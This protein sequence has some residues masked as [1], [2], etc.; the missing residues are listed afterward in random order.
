MTF[1]NKNLK[2]TFEYA[3]VGDIKDFNKNTFS[4]PQFTKI[5]YNMLNKNKWRLLSL[6][7]QNS[8]NNIESAKYK[9]E[10][11]TDINTGIATLKD[12]LYFVDSKNYENGYYIK[13]YLD[14]QYYIEKEV[15]REIIKVSDFKN[16]EELKRN[17]RRIIF[18]YIIDKKPYLMEESKLAKKFPKTYNYLYTIK[19]EL[20]KRDKGKKTYENWYAYGRTQGL[21]KI[22]EKILTPTFSDK[23]RFLLCKK[24]NSLFCNGYSITLKNSKQKELIDN[25]YLD[26]I[27]GLKII[28]KI[29]NSS[30]MN[31]YIQRISYVI[32][33]GYYCYQKQFIRNF[34]L[35]ELFR[36]EVLEFLELDQKA[37]DEFLIKK[38]SLKI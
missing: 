11:L 32:E 1:I 2:D 16:Q 13:N 23:P 7:D 20:A 38:Y 36:D 9:I 17:T 24:K 10:S 37:T 30:I 31:Y 35:P 15:T 27:N 8:I 33:G 5:Y 4:N 25:P 34:T 26:E 22:R 6:K 21:N 29:L 3:L 28:W 14:K 18:P 12:K 19:D